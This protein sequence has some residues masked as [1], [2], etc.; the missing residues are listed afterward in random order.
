MEKPFTKDKTLISDDFIL[1]N[2]ID[3]INS[4]I[5]Y[6]EGNVVPCCKHCNR[7]KNTMSDSEFREWI[8]K[9]YAH[10]IK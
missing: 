3:R 2:G 7:A 6:I 8:K 10:Y 5:G 9:I 1:V 4:N